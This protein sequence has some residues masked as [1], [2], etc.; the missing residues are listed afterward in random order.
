MCENPGMSNPSSDGDAPMDKISEGQKGL[1]EEMQK[2]AEENKEKMQS[3]D[4]GISSEDFAR[5]AKE[6]AQLRKMLEKYSESKREQGLGDKSLQDIIDQME[7][8]EKNLVN[9]RLTSEMLK[10]QEEIMTRLLEAQNA[11]RQ[12][13]MDEKRK[14]E[15]V[16]KER[17]KE[18]PPALAEYLQKRKNEIEVLKRTSPPLKP[19]YKALIDEYY[20]SLRN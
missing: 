16:K 20:Q 18:I 10:R 17:E 7:Q 9:K 4:D 5:M 8:L 14:A 1:N 2:M 12:Q 3:G 13:K 6:Q 11:D 19:F 15:T